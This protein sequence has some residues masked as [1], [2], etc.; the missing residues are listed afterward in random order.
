M[1]DK[2]KLSIEVLATLQVVREPHETGSM[3]RLSCRGPGE[4]PK[5]DGGQWP[6]MWVDV[7]AT[8]KSDAFGALVRCGKGDIVLVN[9]NLRQGSEWVTREGENRAGRL[10]LWAE[11]AY[12]AW[13][14]NMPAAPVDQ[15]I[16]DDD[17]IPF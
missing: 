5:T 17:S 11:E 16:G 13:S 9:G 12:I 10:V 2:P 14:E 1:N 15:P 7:L 8:N 4:K 6:A 3:V